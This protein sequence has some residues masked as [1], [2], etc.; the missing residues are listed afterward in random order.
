[1][2]FLGTANCRLALVMSPARRYKPEMMFPKDIM[3]YEYVPS[4]RSFVPND[5]RTALAT[6]APDRST[7]RPSSWSCSTPDEGYLRAGQNCAAGGRQA[8]KPCAGAP[9]PPRPTQ[10]RGRRHHNAGVV[11]HGVRRWRPAGLSRAPGGAFGL[12]NQPKHAARLNKR[13]RRATV[14]LRSRASV[15]RNRR[16]LRQGE[17]GKCKAALGCWKD[18]A[19]VAHTPLHSLFASR[20]LEWPGSARRR[21][22]AQTH[23]RSDRAS[24]PGIGVVQGQ[25]GSRG[26]TVLFKRI[27]PVGHA[28]KRQQAG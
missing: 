21:R 24:D 28:Q 13:L 2:Y 1:V 25:R 23:S 27:V 3:R 12:H 19:M 14:L 15:S 18:A 5:L 26:A 9:A 11:G 10:P 22:M 16:A 8:P 4:A 17:L 20:G 6:N 7:R